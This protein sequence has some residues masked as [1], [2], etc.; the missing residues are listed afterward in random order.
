[1]DRSRDGNSEDIGGY[2][3]ICVDMGG[4]GRICVDALDMDMGGYS[5]ILE[6]MRGYLWIWGRPKPENNDFT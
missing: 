4:Y 2:G 5:W 3:M 1:M 6:D